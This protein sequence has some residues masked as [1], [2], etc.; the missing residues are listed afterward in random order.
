MALICVLQSP[1]L[2]PPVAPPVTVKVEI[3]CCWAATLGTT[4]PR[5]W[6]N[7]RHKEKVEMIFF[8]QEW[9]WD[10]CSSDTNSILGAQI[11]GLVSFGTS[12]FRL[13]FTCSDVLQQRSIL[14]VLNTT[15]REGLTVAIDDET[16]CRFFPASVMSLVLVPA[17]NL[18]L[19]WPCSSKPWGKV[20]LQPS[21]LL[22]CKITVPRW[23]SKLGILL[24]LPLHQ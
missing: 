13:R 4:L 7:V 17:K 18:L 2:G 6:S 14:G 11:C 12:A 5:P 19:L 16:S 24:Y 10:R 20:N 22:T 1:D 3:W 8:R 23:R 9:I 21:P 15:E